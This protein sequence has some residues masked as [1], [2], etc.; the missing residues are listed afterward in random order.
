VR[1][2]RVHG[3]AV[4][5]HVG[6][7]AV[8]IAGLACD[9]TCSRLALLT[10]TET[11]M[12]INVV[13][14]DQALAPV[15]ETRTSMEH[16]AGKLHL[17]AAGELMFL[18]TADPTLRNLIRH[19]PAPI[20]PERYHG[21]E[22]PEDFAVGPDGLVWTTF[23]QDLYVDALPEFQPKGKY[24]ASILQRAT[25]QTLQLLSPKVGG[26]LAARRDGVLVEFDS[27]ARMVRETPI[28]EDRFTAISR[29]AT[30]THVVAG[31]LAGHLAVID[32]AMQ[33]V[34]HKPAGLLASITALAVAPNGLF[35]VA[36]LDRDLHLHRSNGDLIAKFHFETPI[37]QLTMAPD[38]DTLFI[39]VTGERTVRRW[40]LKTLGRE[41]R[42]AGYGVDDLP[43]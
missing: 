5:S 13:R 39:L 8:P 20:P 7:S 14:P 12:A 15:P 27:A 43:E 18:R 26:C 34:L 4:Q 21:G 22:R 29:D 10:Q 42:A 16:W 41:F 19:P 35:A 33:A 31:S 25:G 38:G 1:R 6:W 3:E 30:G 37:R 24:S 17:S 36:S 9:P 2:W 23:G 11:A 40:N 28:F 32:G